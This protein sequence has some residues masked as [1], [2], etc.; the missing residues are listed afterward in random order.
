MEDMEPPLDTDHRIARLAAAQ[1]GVVRHR[2]LLDLG[3]TQ[4]QIRHRR[5]V[6]R[7]ITLHPEVYAVG[8]D[9]VSPT[10]RRLA[11]VWTYGAKAAL[12]HRSAAAAWGPRASG[13]AKIDVTVPTTA[14]ALKREGTRLHRTGRVLETTRLDRLPITTPARTLLDLAAVVPAHQVEA[15]ASRPT[16]SARCARPTACRSRPPTHGRSAGASTSCARR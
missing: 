12:S 4:P 14:G 16:C 1:H 2:D 15:A 10:G 6:G 11:A 5:E 3:L 7:L 13:A 8:H 9:R